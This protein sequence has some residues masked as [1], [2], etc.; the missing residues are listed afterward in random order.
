MRWIPDG[1]FGPIHRQS[2][3]HTGSLE[4]SPAERALSATSLSLREAL[5]HF[6]PMGALWSQ[7]K[8]RRVLPP[9]GQII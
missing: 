3:L 5:A 8:G 4:G 9:M 2:N 7:A 6:C 1:A